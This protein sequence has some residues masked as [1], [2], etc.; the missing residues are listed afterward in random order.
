MPRPGVSGAENRWRV[1]KDSRR[2]RISPRRGSETESTRR[3]ILGSAVW[4]PAGS[5]TASSAA[6]TDAARW[7]AIDTPHEDDD[8]EARG[9]TRW[10]A[11][12]LLRSPLPPGK[13]AL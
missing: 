4:A 1:P 13:R 3:P 6:R 11:F 7:P 8:T 10:G 9:Y 2:R 5:A 12:R